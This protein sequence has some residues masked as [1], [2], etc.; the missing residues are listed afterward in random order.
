LSAATMFLNVIILLGF[1]LAPV[2]AGWI[3]SMQPYSILLIVNGGIYLISAVILVFVKTRQDHQS[4][5]GTAAEAPDGKAI[6]EEAIP[7]IKKTAIVNQ[8]MIAMFIAMMAVGPVQVLLPEFGKKIL[9]LGESARGAMMGTL[10]M[11]LLLGAIL[12]GW[13]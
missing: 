3:R 12:A 4:T 1:A 8:A 13:I 9:G 6:V 10:G 7:F 2:I 5:T 11:G